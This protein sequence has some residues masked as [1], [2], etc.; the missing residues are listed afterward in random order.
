MTVIPVVV[1]VVWRTNAE[2]I[3]DAQIASQ[4]AV[5]NRDFR[6]TN[7]DVGS[8][9]SVFAPLCAD[10]RI[11]FELA[12]TDPSGNP[13]DGIVRVKTTTADSRTTTRSRP[14]RRVERT[15]GPRTST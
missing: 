6:K 8:T 3:S 7:A 11:E 4:I 13:T 2:N 12:S 10:A 15:P 1:H 14:A 5:L 9:P